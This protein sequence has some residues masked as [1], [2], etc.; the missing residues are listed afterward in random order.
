[1]SQID[2]INGI[3]VIIPTNGETDWGEEVTKAFRLLASTTLQKN[4]TQFTLEAELNFGTNFGI[5]VLYLK[6]ITSDS[7]SSGFL[8]MAAQ[9]NIGW[10]ANDSG[11]GD[12]LLGISEDD[13][14]RFKG[15]DLMDVSSP[16]TISNKTFDTSND[17]N[18]EISLDDIDS[19]TRENPENVG[20]GVVGA[21]NNKLVFGEAG[22]DPAAISAPQIF[23]RY[24]VGLDK[25]SSTLTFTDSDGNR[26]HI[27]KLSASELLPE[28]SGTDIRRL[29][30]T[31]EKVLVDKDMSATVFANISMTGFT[32][33]SGLTGDFSFRARLGSSVERPIL[34]NSLTRVGISP[35]AFKLGAGITESTGMCELNDGTLVAGGR[36]G[37]VG[38]NRIAKV[39]KVTGIASTVYAL[40]VPLNPDK[41]PG[42]SVWYWKGLRD[43]FFNSRGIY[44]VREISGLTNVDNDLYAILHIEHTRRSDPS[45]SA[46]SNSCK[47][48][49]KIDLIEPEIA[50]E[51][52]KAEFSIRIVDSLP[53]SRYR[54][55][56]DWYNYP[57]GY[58]A[59]GIASQDINCLASKGDSMYFIENSSQKLYSLDI[60]GQ[61]TE[62]GLL[63]YPTSTQGDRNLDIHGLTSYGKNFLA[64]SKEATPDTR[65]IVTIPFGGGSVTN[66]F[67]TPIAAFGETESI[68]LSSDGVFA[69]S[70]SSTYL[71]KI[72]TTT[73]RVIDS[74]IDSPVFS[75]ELK[76]S[77]ANP[78]DERTISFNLPR[79]YIEKLT[80]LEVSLECVEFPTGGSNASITVDSLDSSF[81][82]IT[83]SIDIVDIQVT[84][85]EGPTGSTGVQGEKGDQGLKGDPGEDGATGGIGN[86]GPIGP[87]GNAGSQGVPGPRGSD[88]NN[89]TRGP[90]GD[91]GAGG[92]KGDTGDT[93]PAGPSDGPEGPAGAKGDRGLPGVPGQRGVPGTVGSKGSKG[94]PG[95]RGLQGTTGAQGNPGS[96]GDTGDIGP[97]GADSTVPGPAGSKGDRGVPGDIGARGPVGAKGDTGDIGAKGDRGSAGSGGNPDEI[98]LNDTASGLLQIKDG[99]ISRVKLN[100]ELQD[101]IDAGSGVGLIKPSLKDTQLR[102][103]A[104]DRTGDTKVSLSGAATTELSENSIV[105]IGSGNTFDL[106]KQAKVTA[107]EKA[108]E[109]DVLDAT[110]PLHYE[111]GLRVY[112]AATNGAGTGNI[113]NEAADGR[114]ALINQITY[115]SNTRNL[116]L[117][118]DTAR[119]MHEF[120][121]TSVP[122]HISVYIGGVLI[123]FNGV[124][125]R[126]DLQINRY[127]TTHGLSSTSQISVKVSTGHPLILT[128]DKDIVSAGLFNNVLI[129]EQIAN[130][131]KLEHTSPDGNAVPTRNEVQ[132]AIDATV[133]NLPP[134]G[135]TDVNPSN[136]DS[137]ETPETGKAVIISETDADKFDFIEVASQADLDKKVDKTRT[138]NVD[139]HYGTSV[140]PANTKVTGN[141]AEIQEASGSGFAVIFNLSVDYASLVGNYFHRSNSVGLGRTYLEIVSDSTGG[142]SAAGTLV[143]KWGDNADT[144]TFPSDSILRKATP[145]K[146]LSAEEY[147][148]VRK[149][150]ARNTNW[151]VYEKETDTQ[152]AS[153]LIE[154]KEAEHGNTKVVRYI[155]KDVR[156]QVKRI[157]DVEFPNTDDKVDK[158]EVEMPLLYGKSKRAPAKYI[159]FKGASLSHAS[160]E[161]SLTLHF[162]GSQNLSRVIGDYLYNPKVLG[163]GTK[164]IK[165]KSIVSGNNT[166]AVK[167]TLSWDENADTS[168]IENSTLLK[169]SNPGTD[170]SETEYQ[171]LAAIFTGTRT[172]ASETQ[173]SNTWS[174][175]KDV[176]GEEEADLTWDFKSHVER[177][178]A[179]GSA[180]TVARFTVTNVQ[181]GVSV[182]R[183]FVLPRGA[184]GDVG[185]QGP[186]G[187]QGAGGPQGPL[188]LAGPKG[189]TGAQGDAGPEGP[190]GGAADIQDGD[191][192]TQKIADEAVTPAK[193]EGT[194]TPGQ[195]LQ[196]DENGNATW[197][198]SAIEDL[199]RTTAFNNGL[200]EFTAAE[201]ND[202]QEVTL[203]DG[204]DE[205]GGTTKDIF[206]LNSDRTIGITKAFN[207]TFDLSAEGTVANTPTATTEFTLDCEIVKR[208]ITERFTLSSLGGYLYGA[209]RIQNAVSTAGL[210]FRDSAYT[211]SGN[212][213]VYKSASN[214]YISHPN[215]YR[216]N[217]IHALANQSA[218]VIAD[219][220]DSVISYDDNT[221]EIYFVGKRLYRLISINSGTNMPFTVEVVN[222]NTV[223]DSTSFSSAIFIENEF[224]YI[225]DSGETLGRVDVHSGTHTVLHRDLST[226]YGGRVGTMFLYKDQINITSYGGMVW[227][228]NLD[229]IGNPTI[230][231]S[232]VLGSSVFPYKDSTGEG[233]ID[234]R[235]DIRN[236]WTSNPVTIVSSFVETTHQ[237]LSINN[238]FG[239]EGSILN[240]GRVEIPEIPPNEEYA[241]K[242]SYKC[243]SG[244]QVFSNDT[245]RGTYSLDFR[246]DLPTSG[247]LGPEGPQGDQGLRGF[248]GD[249]GDQGDQGEP[250]AE[251]TTGAR[252]PAGAKGDR[253]LRGFKG[254]PGPGGG[255]GDLADVYFEIDYDG[256]DSIFGLY[257]AKNAAP[258][259]G[260]NANSFMVKSADRG[261]WY[262]SRS[263]KVRVTVTASVKYYGRSASETNWGKLDFYV[264]TSGFLHPISSWNNER[265]LPA[266]RSNPVAAIEYRPSTGIIITEVASRATSDGFEFSPDFIGV[267]DISRFVYKILLRIEEL[268]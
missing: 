137:D 65:T 157:F 26:E 262:F 96:K 240:T 72:S 213:R 140:K 201:T 91:Q 166:S 190:Q 74:L 181:T 121:I 34:Q 93:G 153:L 226:V 64:I 27:L 94:V 244:S 222:H 14:L 104:V 51:I 132:S 40:E 187:E 76:Q 111:H 247:Q 118:F 50:G 67:R 88:G 161:E 149:L 203:F 191:V 21:A 136:L 196:T 90:Q 188:G 45:F 52:G 227:V 82:G 267:T 204:F 235:I 261:S 44:R 155:E 179:G 139:I 56:N 20:R 147:I 4:T 242:L 17:Y 228:L 120:N 255:S 170:F 29:S 229:D 177:N 24:K 53:G 3:Q 214:I 107:V 220:A 8:R 131:L 133:N 178:E 266:S 257:N 252:G 208:V 216:L 217:S 212:V 232:S 7:S 218:E 209:A 260:N 246:G 38:K 142:N 259:Q 85:P 49:A 210:S 164:F 180:N 143:L 198:D 202:L 86:Q 102:V 268:P 174:I 12:L 152:E 231:G 69:M 234:L 16:Q 183:D 225:A 141:D 55:D 32:I 117:I 57:L 151:F 176:V 167:V 23:N 97:T 83:E 253:G 215:T 13:V 109:V 182:L 35:L 127:R 195:T 199:T 78:T 89:G 10:K 159:G 138:P 42:Q 173:H 154:L 162:N 145:G 87:R 256:T 134:S 243:D 19:G 192:T 100:Q 95:D 31:Q 71:H 48:L 108:T 135:I 124:N 150:V 98:T 265:V 224:Y 186:Q 206:V 128:L 112:D 70:S 223:S 101:D 156:T 73:T 193:I 207:G 254:D 113:L 68:A 119:L 92:P 79:I 258:V 1:M 230:V 105:Q 115:Q 60:R 9:D 189:I 238:T 11:S 172:N 148:A 81:F 54:Q 175:Y 219:I 126:N 110:V 211:I 233:L 47:M 103:T 129:V 221:K 75:S 236:E 22:A 6:S 66:L 37:E 200:K 249:Q 263:A 169:A 43:P 205:V 28:N 241:I 33:P 18:I 61:A 123:V 2:I 248:K 106:D 250:G 160:G 171:V 59:V 15:I 245:V 264:S 99:G 80:E 46:P 63:E 158:S 165:L 39:D 163:L 84:G 41:V 239:A 77:L 197:G 25:P 144:L 125:V 194:N 58:R 146:R 237:N 168:L 114:D 184:T 251:G 185:T 116:S 130:N 5:K 62:S 30:P 122:Q 36:S